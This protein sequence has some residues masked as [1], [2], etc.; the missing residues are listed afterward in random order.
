MS[1]DWNGFKSA[2]YDVIATIVSDGTCKFPTHSTTRHIIMVA[3]TLLTSTVRNHL[4][5][6][7]QKSTCNKLNARSIRHTCRT[8]LAAKLQHPR[9]SLFHFRQVY[10][11]QINLDYLIA[12]FAQMTICGHASKLERYANQ[13]HCQ[14]GNAKPW[15]E[16]SRIG[17]LKRLAG[18]TPPWFLISFVQI[19]PIMFLINDQWAVTALPVMIDVSGVGSSLWYGIKRDGT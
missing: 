8:L 19:S 17:P 5:F 15:L 13:L 9:Q 1:F 6:V 11:G 12:S 3:I 4:V 14:W 10:V 16:P 2:D 18:N 7:V